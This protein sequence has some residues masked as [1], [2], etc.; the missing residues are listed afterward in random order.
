MKK[1]EL[2][3]PLSPE[4]SNCASSASMTKPVPPRCARG[5]RHS[6]HLLNTQGVS[7]WGGPRTREGN[8]LVKCLQEFQTTK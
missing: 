3:F 5:T 7:L 6:I 1:R 4:N 2:V 8:N